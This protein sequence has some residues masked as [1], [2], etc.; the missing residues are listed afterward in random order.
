MNMIDIEKGSGS[1]YVDLDITDVAEMQVKAILASKIGEIIKLQRLTQIQAAEILC[2]PQ[3]ALSGMLRGQFRGISE[4]E[5][6]DYL[7][8]LGRNIEIV[9]HKPSRTR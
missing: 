1:V 9:A 4:A 2:M 6:L 8:R 7:N 3:P 5:M